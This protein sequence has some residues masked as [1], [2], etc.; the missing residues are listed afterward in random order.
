MMNLESPG[1]IQGE[2]QGVLE[3]ITQAL[4]KQVDLIELSEIK[5]GSPIFEEIERQGVLLYDRQG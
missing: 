4:G 5:H 3:D 1:F 2:C